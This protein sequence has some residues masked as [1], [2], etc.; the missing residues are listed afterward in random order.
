MCDPPTFLFANAE[1][2]G[3]TGAPKQKETDMSKTVKALVAALVVATASVTL[4][5][6]SYAAP[7]QQQ[8]PS[9]AESNWMDHASQNV[10]SG[11]N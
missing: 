1:Y 11:G 3:V 4:A 2:L 7:Q 8:G 9:A 10:D 6:N 5:A